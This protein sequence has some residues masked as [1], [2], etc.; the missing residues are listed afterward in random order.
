M[1]NATVTGT[2]AQYQ[3]DGLGWRG[4]TLSAGA[5]SAD[6]IAVT[7]QLVDAA[8]QSVSEAATVV[9]EI[10]GEAAAAYTIAATTGTE[11]GITARPGLAVTTTAAGVAVFDVTDVSGG[12][13]A[14][15]VF[16]ATVCDG[17]FT[18]TSTLAITFDDTDS[19]P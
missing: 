14:S 17:P 12:S 9:V 6:V 15:V 5:E 8:G 19:S 1:G 18:T 13:D 4:V 7:L 2:R 3:L 11:L 10:V 16:L